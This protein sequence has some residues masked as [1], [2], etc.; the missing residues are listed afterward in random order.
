MPFFLFFLFAAVPA[1]AQTQTTPTQL[2]T[3]TTQ[4]P[5][6]SLRLLGYTTDNQYRAISLGSG[7]QVEIRPDGSA[8]VSVDLS[9]I[10]VRLDVTALTRNSDGSYSGYQPGCAVARN[11]VTQLPGLDFTVSG[12]RVIPSPAFP[13]WEGIDLLNGIRADVVTVTCPKVT[14]AP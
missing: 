2:R 6:S 1:A 5:A 11:G 13:A 9:K 3:G 10:N 4:V 14:F 7:I 12:D 8:H